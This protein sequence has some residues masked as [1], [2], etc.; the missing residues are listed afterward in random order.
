MPGLSLVELDLLM[1]GLTLYIVSE[2]RGWEILVIRATRR[3]K[4]GG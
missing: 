2:N 4:G 1:I 3:V